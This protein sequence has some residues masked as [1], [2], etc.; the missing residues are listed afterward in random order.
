MELWE[1][2]L[3]LGGRKPSLTGKN[4]KAYSSLKTL[5]LDKR[6][7]SGR[8]LRDDGDID[9]LD[10]CLDEVDDRRG[11]IRSAMLW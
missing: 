4:S 10:D 2:P 3:G 7:D 8:R 9:D 6:P 1:S 5:R 11:G